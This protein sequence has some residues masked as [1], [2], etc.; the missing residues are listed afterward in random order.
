MGLMATLSR[1]LRRSQRRRAARRNSPLDM[2]RRC[3]FELMESRR[4]LDADPL[5]IGAVYIE[6]DIGSDAHGDS[7][8]LT[9]QGGAPGTQLQRVVINGDRAAPGF[10]EGDVFFDIE[11]TGY[12]ADHAFPFTLVSF[13][14]QDPNAQATARVDD[15]GTQLVIDLIG[16][17]AG[18][19]LVFS[20]DVDEVEQFDSNETDPLLIQD[21][22]D[23]ITSG[24]E[25]QG[26]QLEAYFSAPHYFEATATAEFRNRYDDALDAS[27]LDLP[28]DDAD[29]KRDRTAGAFG[30]ALQEPLPVTISGTVYLDHDLDLQ[31]DGGETGLAG[32]TLELFRRDADT[33]ASTGHTTTTDADG[34]Y[35]FGVDLDL[36]PGV[37]QVREQQPSGLFSVGAVPGSVA[38]DATGVTVAGNRDVL[39][40]ISIPLGGQSAVDM[41]F[42]EARPASIS[43][44]VY[45]DQDNDGER[46]AGET[47]IGN[48]AVRIVPIDTI[49][50]QTTIDTTTDATGFYQ[51]AGLPPGVYRVI[52]ATQPVDYFDGLDAVGAVDGQIRG[53]AVNPGD[54]LDDILLLGG[55]SGVEFNFGELVPASIGGRVQ[56]S[57]RDGDCFGDPADHPPLAGVIVRLLNEQGVVLQETTTN[58]NGEY[59]FD[60]LR[61]GTYAVQE[62]TPAGL[63]DGGEQVGSIDGLASGVVASNDL[64]TGIVIGSAQ[65]GTGYDFCEHLPAS[66][67]GH[68]FHDAN[69]NGAREAGE[70]PITGVTVTLRDSGNAVV[71][72]AVTDADGRYDF[73]GLRAGTYALHESQP[74]G[75][76]DG[77]D[78]AGT[79]AGTTN[80]R[81]VS[82]DAIE[83]VELAWGD[84]G[85]DYDFG[86]LIPVSL[87]GF[88]Y[89]D[90]ANNGQRD[91]G[92]EGL[93]G[94]QLTVVPVST[95]APQSSV[96]VT[97][98]ADGFYQATGLSPGTYRIV[99]QQPDGFVDGTDVAGTV[100]G[101][102][103]GSAA[104][105]GD[106]ISAITLASGESGVQYNFGEF[107]R[108]SL[109]GRVHL[110]D[111]D[112]DCF[113]DG[114]V[115]PP[116]AGVT[117]RLLADDGSVLQQTTTAADGTYRFDDLLPGEY[118]VTADTPDG[119]ID[120]EHRV[121]TVDGAT[122][123]A[124]TGN[125]LV[126]GIV[127][128]S[129][130]AGVDY[131]FCEHP[132]ASLAGFV[133][134]DLNDN[135]RFDSGEAPIAGAGVQLRND[136]GQA[137]ATA[138]TGADGSY[139]FTGLR[140]GTY[141]LS[142]TQ[143]TGWSDG[144]DAPGTIDG[145]T[146]GRAAGSDVIDQIEL[147]WGQAGVH[148]D[149]GE[150]LYA[151]VS[152]FVYHDRANDGARDAG[153]EGL[154]GVQVSIIPVATSAPQATV[155]VTTNADGF[156]QATGLSPG[157]YRITEQQPGGYVDGRDS[158]GTV[159]G[160]P[161]GAAQNPGDAIGNVRLGSGEHGVQ[162]NFGEFQLASLA[163]RVH[164]SSG[165]GD[166]FDDSV[167]HAPL[168]GVAVQLMDAG[169]QVVQTTATAADGTYRF[170]GLLPGEYAV[171]ATTPNGLID[172]GERVGSVNG[173]ANGT[174]DG[175]DRIAGIVLT[176]GQSGIQYDF[177][178]HEPAALTGFVF[179]DANDNGKFDNGE[180]PIGGVAVAL[181]D[182]SGTEIATSLTGSDG[183][184]EFTGLH[185]GTYSLVESQPGGWIDGR[186]AVGSIAGATVGQIAGA[187]TIG[188]IEL[189][190]GTSGVHYDFGELQPVSLSGLVYHDRANNGR[191]D[192]GDE[193]LAGVSLTVI[194][195]S[196]SAPQASVTVT[197]DTAGFYQATGL[198]P[199]V[200][201]IVE[202]QPAGFV[203]G[204][205]QP[206][207]VGGESRGVAQ[208]PGDAIA[209]IRLASGEHGV[210]YDFGEF[211]L[212]S[213]SGLVHLTDA[214]GNCDTELARQ[215]TVAGAH[216]TL[217][218]ATG[219]AV[220]HAT[221][222]ADGVYR[223]SGLLPGTYS[224]VEQTPDGLIDGDEHAGT[225]N[226]QTVGQVVANDV[227][228]GISL[229]SGQQSIGNDFCEHEPAS[230]SGFVYHDLDNDGLRDSGEAPIE[231][232]TVRLLDATGQQVATTRTGA[233]GSYR[234]DGLRAGVYSVVESQPDGWL[235]G[236]D[237]AGTVDGQPSGAAGNDVI[238]SVHLK[239]GQSG[240][241]FNFGELQPGGISGLVFG[242]HNRNCILD[243]VDQP[244]AG[245]TVQ[246]LDA[247][248]HVVAEQ[249]TGEDGTYHFS[250]LRPGEYTV[251]Q[252]QPADHFHGDQLA[253]SAGGADHLDNVISGI[254][255]G[256]GQLVAEYN[257]CEVPQSSLSG[258]VFQD[259]PT[260]ETE[261]GQAPPFLEAIRDGQFTPD[262]VPIAGVVLELRDGLSGDVIDATE[263]LP[264]VYADGPVRVTTDAQGH[265]R[266]SGLLGGRSYAV[267]E[268]QP[269][270]FADHI[271]TPG[272]TSGIAFNQG[273][274]VSPLILQTLTAEPNNDAIVRIPLA[275]GQHSENNNFSEVHI[276]RERPPALIAPPTG[277]ANSFAAGPRTT[278]VAPPQ[279]PTLAG[280]L[281]R[282]VNVVRVGGINVGV[283]YTWHLSVI[284]AGLPRDL[285]STAENAAGSMVWRT[286]TYLDQISWEADRMQSTQW[287]LA[288]Y[289][290][291]EDDPEA[292]GRVTLGEQSV[293]FGLYGAIPVSG[294]FNGDGIDEL[295][296]YYE[297]EWF[298]DLN[299]NGRWDREDLWA[300][301][302]GKSDLPVTG[303]WDGDG[304]D[305]IGIYGPE[306]EGDQ[307]AI[308]HEPGLPD[309]ANSPSA[310]PK[311]VPPQQHEA[312]NGHRLMRLN[313]D[314][315][316]RA[317]VIDH[318][319]RF[320][321]GR[322]VPVAGDWNGD[323][324]R[325]IGIYRDGRWRLDMD[326]D[327][328]W[329]DRDV[330]AEFGSSGD[331]PV[332]G[333]FDGNG[334][335]E[336]GI[337]RDGVWHIDR[338]GDRELDAH[339]RVFE[340]GGAG[341]LPVVGDWDGDGTDDPALFR[342]TN[343]S[344]D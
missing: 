36:K 231:G 175:N 66:L 186:D 264:G 2:P 249:Q 70:S 28:A 133:Y 216:V 143:P 311:N 21:G 242:D 89:H 299:G 50:P 294:D 209:G 137:V 301:L 243:G 115:H 91:A 252:V 166:C 156:Y 289:S 286:G 291:D 159:A 119:V 318:V 141:S 92:D 307:R 100:G 244:L 241:D 309:A 170:D 316:R 224:V 165:D 41:D 173:E 126:S 147:A 71:G 123:G 42:A 88:V 208:N 319:F 33:Y 278:L 343:G 163:G 265:Y 181:L 38:G 199:G 151:G 322:S 271:D 81:V 202:Q 225:V 276:V 263:T 64:L 59:R 221:T 134:H 324:I 293:V 85:V 269:E 106:A 8:E 34:N 284:D 195:V 176:S 32:V 110:S 5:Q 255:V 191:R 47:G 73:T 30:N 103:R 229:T 138:T 327:G 18:D 341:D 96:T 6:E 218:D 259:G 12:G 283:S 267:Y 187:D 204:S 337:F 90:R 44:F 113:A 78:A 193:G 213:I 109:A 74:A 27:G 219:N 268:I 35:T 344:L 94:V 122:N 76:I 124:I 203:D 188:Q 300:K 275:I 144:K 45:H 102:T 288:S 164:L 251:R 60:G 13:T 149:F 56:L 99:E 11:E 168:A 77:Q 82:P 312:T 26:S 9:F 172:G 258:F 279:L 248:S 236:R 98:D 253:G 184:Y 135:G 332:V 306:W 63:I 107:Q 308:K 129:G 305:D 20:I 31:Q 235:D 177:C 53:V 169:G 303:D 84:A 105:P 330:T 130:Q 158:A 297:G 328:R 320:G 210:Q 167:A 333:D 228:G 304:K 58:D 146:V 198:A 49:S 340:L 148:Y 104:K 117:V 185:A 52:E 118:A 274:E 302:G 46:D 261:D 323:G 200:Y 22:F 321:V 39:T 197:T 61:P 95:S 179:H 238:A 298:I 234:M 287:V 25:F 211:Q 272:T 336:I 67:S 83:L 220:A 270:G 207:T 140:K 237:A 24:V 192:A 280:P 16:F 277:P 160:Q 80:G 97:T 178:E 201:R 182:S 153:D 296:V 10:G 93:A 40:T 101:A 256:S 69:D 157:T 111:A 190:W 79:I 87:S 282:E 250:G 183:A 127:L 206:G 292:D 290:E 75:W 180:S 215:S 1:L 162:Y 247:Q 273:K 257:F 326:G 19:K 23:P 3:R 227:I 155:V 295:G 232:A 254:L 174:V 37:Y 331:L 335:D 233:D 152:G 4:L 128:T 7:F 240:R 132:P 112:G 68:V 51:V 55:D 54:R 245:V 189:A 43:G 196:S 239:W 314:G 15:G 260:L 57:T 217:L 116:L 338:D 246:V 154:E 230:I 120:G 339:D 171:T 223:F 48:V 329:T 310:R 145:V 266:F 281:I 194:P 125:D 315:P 325:T 214:D 285:N 131:D 142:E 29:G 342:P 226:A 317:D 62:V 72:T 150:L 17:S 14:S 334:V 161:R 205:D 212:S 65:T 108:A 313:A 222:D 139:Q 121:G 114:V 136:A 86:E 262:D